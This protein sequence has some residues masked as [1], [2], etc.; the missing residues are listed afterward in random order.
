MERASSGGGRLDV[1]C[2]SLRGLK[3]VSTQT[4]GPGRRVR[5]KQGEGHV[6]WHQELATEP[7]EESFRVEGRPEWGEVGRGGSLQA[8]SREQRVR[9]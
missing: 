3:K 2:Q 5:A 1:G 6:A 8:G 9:A 7:G 4:A